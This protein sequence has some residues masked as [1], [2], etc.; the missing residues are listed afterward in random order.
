MAEHARLFTLP[1]DEKG[2][3]PLVSTLEILWEQGITSL[4]VEGGSRV[5]TS[6]L[7][8]GLADALILTIA[9]RFIGGYNA[10]GDLGS[11]RL[12]NLPKLNTLHSAP[13]G[14]DQI[15]WGTFTQEGDEE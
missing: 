2:Y 12:E 10:T 11:N 8:S 5:I 9:P 15:V 1:P 14:E 4:M 7:K 3:V 13:L 6:F